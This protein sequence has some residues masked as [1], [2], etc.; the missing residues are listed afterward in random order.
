MIPVLQNK[1][2]DT[3]L[4]SFFS[5]L[6]KSEQML[7]KSLPF[8]DNKTSSFCTCFTKLM[9]Y[10]KILT[11]SFFLI[12]L[13][14][15]QRFNLLPS[16]RGFDWS[17]K[18]SWGR[19]QHPPPRSQWFGLSEHAQTAM[20]NLNRGLQQTLPPHFTCRLIQKELCLSWEKNKLGNILGH[21]V[22]DCFG[23]YR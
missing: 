16:N 10:C 1:P 15:W 5:P 6:L 3:K 12:R 19:V 2:S 18:G 14:A 4:S 9:I 22:K 21:F 23:I 11:L 20:F 7:K 8:K 13:S 17:V